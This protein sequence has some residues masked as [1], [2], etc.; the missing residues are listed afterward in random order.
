M[1]ELEADNNLLKLM[2]NNLTEARAATVKEVDVITGYYEKK[3][4]EVEV[5]KSKLSE[6][7]FEMTPADID[8]ASAQGITPFMFK[9]RTLILLQIEEAKRQCFDEPPG[10]SDLDAWKGRCIHTPTSIPPHAH[11]PPSI[12][13]DCTRAVDRA[14]HHRAIARS[15]DVLEREHSYQNRLVPGRDAGCEA[16]GG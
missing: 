15:Y 7:S 2:V 1:T 8:S 13:Q 5:L 12:A 4:E 16:Q 14:V 11:P 6:S 3:V 10:L 9:M